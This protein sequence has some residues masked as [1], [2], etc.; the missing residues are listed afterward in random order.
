MRG[1]R[2]RSRR[3]TGPDGWIRQIVRRI[4]RRT[5][6]SRV[7]LFGSHAHGT[8]GPQS[9][10]DLLVVLD[11]PKSLD[12][13]YEAVEDAVGDHLWPLDLLVCGSREVEARLRIGDSFFREVLSRG[14]VLH[15]ESRRGPPCRGTRVEGRCSAPG[16]GGYRVLSRPTV[17]REAHQGGPGPARGRGAEEPRSGGSRGIG[18]ALRVPGIQAPGRPAVAQPVR[19]DDTLSGPPSD[20]GPGEGRAEVHALRHVR[21]RPAPLSAAVPAPSG[22]SPGP[23]AYPLIARAPAVCGGG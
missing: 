1:K 13:R 18:A 11:R 23:E 15:L 6:P 9:D 20:L 12:R 3:D 19:G 21:G 14:R 8:P 22:R 10:V 7:I 2:P 5:H 17:R 16:P 4:V